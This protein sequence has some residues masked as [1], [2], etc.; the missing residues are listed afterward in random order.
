MDAV[1]RLNSNSYIWPTDVLSAL[2]ISRHDA[3][4]VG[5]TEAEI[6][7]DRREVYL[8]LRVSQDNK[9]ARS[10]SY[11][12]TLLPGIEMK[13]VFLTLTGPSGDRPSKIKDGEAVGFGYY[14]AER[15]IEIPVAGLRSRGFYHLEI[16][17]T[18]RSGGVAAIEFWFYHPGS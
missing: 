18:I 13:E 1:Q 15:P 4:I 11:S 9:S 10:S 8:P 17:A 7:G 16:G 6:A 2:N 5:V 14:P 3:G 12:L